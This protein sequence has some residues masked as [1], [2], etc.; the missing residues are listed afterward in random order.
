M[1]TPKAPKKP[2]T[3]TTHGHTRTDNYFWM[4]E[5]DKPELLNYINAENAYTDAGLAHTKELQATLYDEMV[6]RIQE[7]DQS[8]PVEK[9]GYFYYT[10]TEE[11]LQYSIYCRKQGNM[12]ADEQ[13]LLN[14]N[15]IAA[16]SDSDY[17]KVGIFDVSP[18]QA[19]LAYSLDTT[20]G[21]RYTVY[22]KDLATGDI[23]PDQ[24][25]DAGYSF[26]W[27]NDSQTVFYDRLD[28]A[29]RS[30]QIWRFRFGDGDPESTLI[31]QEDDAEF[32][33]GLSKTRD[34]C[35]ILMGIDAAETS[36]IHFLN[37]NQPYSGF[38]MIEARSNGI[39]YDIDHRDGVFYI[40]T[41]CDRATN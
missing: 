33:V 21:E 26:E 11:G 31:F 8:V 32:D 13:I 4:R 39:D 7:T 41:N 38:Q 9:N 14:P 36:E 24:I 1:K 19:I 2:Y 12:D 35:Y 17:L 23:R 10:R 3:I 30:Y 28:E 5:K 40:L 37:A 29:W 22:F 6:G 20:G 16:E 25:E 34:D 18:D 15:E 27:A